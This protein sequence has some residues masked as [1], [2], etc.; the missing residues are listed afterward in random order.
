MHN[1][2]L[3]WSVYGYIG[4]Y[5][6]SAT[7]WR[8]CRGYKIDIIFR[9]RL[10][11]FRVKQCRSNHDTTGTLVPAI[12]LKSGTPKSII[13]DVISNLEYLFASLESDSDF[14]STF[15]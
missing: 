15:V 2:Y 7:T 13:I 10:R 8:Y 6:F 3:L 12:P 1:C 4:V 11:M 9:C 5:T 14:C